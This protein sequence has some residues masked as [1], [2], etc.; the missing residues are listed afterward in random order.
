[1]ENL[2]SQADYYKEQKLYDKAIEKYKEALDIEKSI[3]SCVNLAVCF[4]RI[5]NFQ[6]A[7][8]CL[9]GLIKS[10]K[11]NS[12]ESEEEYLNIL[13][14]R[15]RIFEKQSKL[16]EAIEDLRYIL[17]KSRNSELKK[18]A[19]QQLEKTTK[20]R[21]ENRENLTKNDERD[22]FIALFREHSTVFPGSEWHVVSN[23][24]FKK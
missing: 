8:A 13:L 6:E 17:F 5:N 11:L 15:S 19:Q 24:W 4:E 20:K 14:Q 1:M 16:S 10:M 9:T 21:E 22:K 3:H 18:I 2:E 23:T 12:H 7:E